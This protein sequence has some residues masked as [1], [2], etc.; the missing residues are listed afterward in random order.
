MS[1]AVRPLS[2]LADDMN[3]RESRFA[4]QFVVCPA[5]LARRIPESACTRD[6]QGLR[7][8]LGP[9][10]HFHEAAGTALCLCILGCVF[11][12]IRPQKTPGE[13]LWRL[14][15]ESETQE[16][17]EESLNQ[18]GGRY[19]ALVSG[20][21]GPRAHVDAMAT[22][23]LLHGVIEQQRV[24]TSSPRMLLQVT[25]ATVMPNS[26]VDRFLA[27]RR[28]EV[29]EYAWLGT[30]SA[31]ARLQRV[32]PNHYVDM[33]AGRVARASL[34]DCSTVGTVELIEHWRD[35]L[36]GSFNCLARLG[37][38]A[39]PVTAGWDSRLLFAASREHSSRIYHYIFADGAASAA[40]VRIA[41]RLCDL[42]G[43]KLHVVHAPSTDQTFLEEYRL[44]HLRPRVLPKT[45]HI[46]HHLR[47]TPSSTI[48]VT[49]V[50]G[51]ILRSYY[52]IGLDGMMRARLGSR[53][54]CEMGGFGDDPWTRCA[55]QQWLAEA[56]SDS[57]AAGIPI[58]DLFYWEQRMGNWGSLY[59]NEQDMAI[60]QVSPY[61]HRRMLLQ[62][63]RSLRPSERCAPHY[64]FTQQLLESL[65]PES[66]SIPVNP[67]PRL[68]ALTRRITRRYSVAKLAARV[69]KNH[70]RV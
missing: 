68:R 36:V 66:A 51:E 41:Q 54:L 8:V 33:R 11:D 20:P 44:G 38:L 57:R 67:E 52:G 62:A 25:G 12:P 23:R 48:N 26:R 39:L 21:L 50:G 4:R 70:I 5:A 58:V 14:V 47:S 63:L 43:V 2:E 30:A 27:S 42:M 35:M 49:G 7:V 40:E 18:L 64:R 37:P 60:E 56:A 16:D 15:A 53:A 46:Q 32:L 59:A 31:D 10:L 28:A 34:I 45:A 29:T 22:R 55:V 69:V 61:N 65:W 19:V 13:L 3:P 24:L 1:A 17:L 9:G 6:W